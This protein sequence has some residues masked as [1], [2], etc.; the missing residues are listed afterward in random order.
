[1]HHT[2]WLRP[3]SQTLDPRGLNGGCTLAYFPGTSATKCKILVEL[4]PGSRLGVEGFRLI[5]VDDEED[6]LVEDC[7]LSVAFVV[8]PRFVRLEVRPGGQCYK[9]FYGRKLRLYIIS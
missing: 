6:V 1:V 7:R 4:S 9:T 2:S 8:L 5:V 3:Y